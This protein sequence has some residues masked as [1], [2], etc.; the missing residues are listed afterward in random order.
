MVDRSQIKEITGGVF[1]ALTDFLLWQIFLVGATVG[2]SG[3]RG[4]YQAFKEA[5]EMLASVNHRSL[6]ATWNQLTQKKLIIYQKRNNLYYP[7]ITEFGRKRLEERMPVYREKRPWD[8]RIYLITYDIPEI[9]HTKRDA[10]RS[11]LIRIRC[12]LL[13]ESVWLI[14]YNP[15]ELIAVF[16]KDHSVPGTVII[17]DVGK[18]GGIGETTVQDLVVRLYSL[19]TLNKRYYDFISQVTKITLPVKSMILKYL[20]ILDD[21]P[22]L[23]FELLPKGWLGDKAYRQYLKLK[24]QII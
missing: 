19:E 24:P 2:K 21:D 7:V 23:P 1:G 17:S 4:V 20:S 6:A 10:L 9:K 5:D 13:Q 8:G 12:K 22:Q 15:R 16:L 11:F 14:P 18:D 3:T